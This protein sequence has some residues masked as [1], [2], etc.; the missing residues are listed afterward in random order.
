MIAVTMAKLASML[1]LTWALRKL[2]CAALSTFL[3]HFRSPPLPH[4]PPS[5][6]LPTE[7]L[8]VMA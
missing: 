8:Q 2:L 1:Q 7:T 5:P 3:F 6:P 4:S